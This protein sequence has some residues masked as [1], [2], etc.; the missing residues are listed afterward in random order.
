MRVVLISTYE[1]GRQPFGLASPAAWLRAAGHEVTCA[2]LAVGS[3]P[4]VEVQQADLVALYLPMHTATRLAQPVLRRIR[5]EN[6]SAHLCC[7][8]LYAPLNEVHLRSLGVQSILGGEFEE[9]LTRLADTLT[10]G[11]LGIS[12]TTLTRLRFLVPD[13]ARLPV[14]ER[15]PKLVTAQGRKRVGYAEA[16]RGCKHVCRHCP[17]VPVYKGA[18]RVVQPDVVLEDIRRQVADGAQHITFGDPD[19]LNGPKHA[20]RVIEGLHRSHPELT[21]DVT[22]KIE[23]LLAHRELI[24]V[25][26]DTGC[27]FVTTAVESTD[28]DVLAILEK[29]HTCADFI[30]VTRLF[31]EAGLALAPTFIPFTPWTTAE[32]LRR[33]LALVRDLGLIEAVAP[34]QWSLRLLIPSGSRLLELADIQ[35]VIG[36]FDTGALVYPWRHPSPAV[37]ELADR[38]SKVVRA[39]VANKRSRSEVFYDIWQTLHGLPAKEDYALVP[40]STIPYMEEPWF[41]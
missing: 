40:R 27:V 10:P 26:R 39:G 15:Y 5:Q 35:S 4:L 14:L 7:Y 29:R 31:E 23:H 11:S 8:G 30:E 13:R 3:L 37:D 25:L 17:V 38:V 33:M 6:P 19:F 9:S 20:L 18:F 22:A 41:C 21:Y 1:L 34:V 12:E 2:D 32:G 36:E 16:S 28:D 24:P